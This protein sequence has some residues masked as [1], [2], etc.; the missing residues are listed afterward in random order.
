MKGKGLTLE[1][2]V[3][4][5]SKL[6]EEKGYDKFSVRELAVRLNVQ[7][8]SLYNH[9]D[10]VDNVNLEV[11]RLAASRLNDTLTQATQTR[12]RDDA[13]SALAY[14]YRQFVRDSPE[15]YRAIIGLP[16]LDRGD[17]LRELGRQS[18]RVVWDVVRQYGVDSD[19]AVHFSRCFRG[20]LHGFA[21]LESAG[22]YTGSPAPSEESFRFLIRGYT[23]WVHSLEQNSG[24]GKEAAAQ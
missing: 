13:L 16:S 17:G 23:D 24:P 18:I 22:Y 21:L 1:V 14:A 9:I 19:A 8:A 7:A 3:D 20:A 5:A 2:I 10:S 12:T 15:L 11:G 6:V 4:T